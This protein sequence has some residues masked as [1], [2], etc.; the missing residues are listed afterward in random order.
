M[1]WIGI[2]NRKGIVKY[3]RCFYK[4]NVVFLSVM[5]SFTG[6]PFKF[7]T[8]SIIVVTSLFN[9]A[10]PQN[11]KRSP[12]V[13]QTKGF[14]R[15]T[16]KMRKFIRSSLIV[17]LLLSAAGLGLYQWLLADL[18]DPSA[19]NGRTPPPSIRITDRNGRLLYDLLDAKNG[20]HTILP[21]DQIPLSLQQAAI[22]TE[23]K[24]FYQNPGVDV[25][26]II[27]AAW[28]NLRGGEV[29]AGG[30]T[31]TQQVARTL[32]LDADERSQ[33]TLRRKLRESW[34]AWQL[35]REYE[36][37]EILA[38]YLNHTYYGGMAYGVAAA[39]QTYFGK[40]AA[41]LTPAESALLA[42]LPQAPAAY[43]P[44]AHP[45]AAKARQEVVLD[46][47]WQEGFIDS[48]AYDLARRQPLAYTPAPY[49]LLAPHFVSMVEAELDAL[50]SPAA[51][52]RYGGLTV[53]TTLDWNWQ[54]QAEEIVNR[55]I[56][57]LNVPPDGGPGHNA[58][59]AA[60]IALDPHDG[61][62][63]ALVGN[64]D[65]FDET[66]G[67]AINMALAP[68][69][70][71]SAL[72]PVIYAAALSPDRSQPWTAASLLADV[73]TTF[74]T[75]EGE[76]YVP[77]N[78][79]RNEH[80]PVLV[81]PSL[82][83]SLNIPAVQVLD[84]IGVD[85]AVQFATEMGITTL[86]EPDS[87]DLSFA[88]GG[89]AVRLLDLTAVYG[90]FA[91]GGSRIQPYLILDVM[92][93]AGEVV[94]TAVPNKPVR[95]LDERVAWLISD[96]LSDDEARRLSF[97]ANSVLRLD[98]PA[99][100]KTGTT[101]QFR[102]NWTV[103]YTP[104]L[105]VGVWVGNADNTPMENI[106]G[107]SGA[108]PIWHQFMRQA[109]AGTPAVPFARPDG[110]TRVEICALS[111]LLPGAACPFRRWEWFITGTE[112]VATDTFYRRVWVE[113][114]T[115]RLAAADA[116]EG[117]AVERLAL[118]LP[119][120][121]H[122]W[123]RAEGLLL[124]ADLRPARTAAPAAETPAADPL[125][126]LRLVS[127]DPN[128]VYRLSPALPPDA[129]KLRLEAVADGRFTAVRFFLDGVL[130]AE[131]N[132]PPYRFWW[133]MTPGRHTLQVEG[134]DDGG[135]VVNGRPVEFEVRTASEN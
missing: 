10:C 129:Q 68:R 8:T 113:L 114:T 59:N 40:P 88:L 24:N 41:D 69:Q 46:L 5:F 90:A 132:W 108:G 57:R 81:R 26:G 109:L 29:L 135:A 76:P 20:R 130:L 7:H 131:M 80:G 17:I 99:A 45:D 75:H 86:G 49:P 32:L 115:G 66:H 118:D 120:V 133:R 11:A 71:G 13:K 64:A 121:F 56:E 116:P 54:E 35:A 117:T 97:G 36:K 101:T 103:G 63:L 83:A 134:R 96:I 67:G 18:P 61:A 31:I 15:Y 106:S 111:G 25:A 39:A 43:N 119:G 102:D 51:I 12:A 82:A 70:P 84:A 91:N 128:T 16:G 98:R 33:R 4:I 44:F 92:D 85:T 126:P 42:G 72:K 60:L 28:I 74:M 47:M 100:V 104:D 22:A 107:V 23:D 38:L 6:I 95:A 89:G 19:I 94:Y 112:P 125:V 93:A 78:Y 122:P 9:P 21:L 34:L 50:F 2:S 14:I 37:D 30:S 65:Y 87:Y 110:L 105:V 55:Q 127:P 123:A 124:L 58:H 77:L 48:L 79:S 27:R 3:C 52:A 62:A 73:R 1:I 53:R